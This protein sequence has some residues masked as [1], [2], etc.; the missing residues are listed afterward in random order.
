MIETKHEQIRKELSIR[1]ITADAAIPFIMAYHYSRIMPRISKVYLGIYRKERLLGVVT[2]GW[3]TQPLQTIRKLFYRHELVTKDYLEIGKMCFAPEMNGNQY[4]G[5]M[6]LSL[7]IK[8]MKRNT[9]CLFLYTLSDGIMGKPGYVYQAGNFQYIGKFKSSVYRDRET[10]EKI[11]PRS[12]KILLAENARLDG[13]EK[14]YWLTHDYCEYKGIE[15]IQ[16]FMFRYIYPVCKAGKKVLKSYEE[17]RCRQ[18]NPKDADLIFEKRV[19]HGK[20]ERTGQPKFN[21]GV[22][23]YQKADGDK[24]S[25]F[26]LK[27]QQSEAEALSEA[28]KEGNQVSA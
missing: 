10:G 16:G 22:F 11:H 28:G 19:A 2:L 14:R 21:M 26:A 15:K 18:S 8:W 3:G 27:E 9:D 6:V 20:F 7:L 25:A 24:L 13:V 4:F 12:A 1:E 17:Y 5:S 23:K